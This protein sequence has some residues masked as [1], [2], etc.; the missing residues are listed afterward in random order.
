MGSPFHLIPLHSELPPISPFNAAVV[1]VSHTSPALSDGQNAAAVATADNT[2]LLAPS[3]SAANW[4][5]MSTCAS[6]ASSFVH[7]EDFDRDDADEDEDYEAAEEEEEE[8]G[9]QPTLEGESELFENTSLLTPVGGRDDEEATERVVDSLAG[10]NNMLKS[11]VSDHNRRS[12]EMDLVM[13]T[14]DI[15]P[16][17]RG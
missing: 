15:S 5:V 12:E 2:R 11:L 16:A 17:V 14:R 9:M 8:E 10:I 6:S 7:R 3:Q 1:A 4:S 13:G